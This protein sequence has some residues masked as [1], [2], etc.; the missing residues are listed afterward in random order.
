MYNDLN[1]I[2]FLHC[3]QVKNIHFMYL[4]NNYSVFKINY[5]NKTRDKIIGLCAIKK[6]FTIPIHV[7]GNHRYALKYQLL[8]SRNEHGIVVKTSLWRPVDRGVQNIIILK[9][10]Q[11]NISY[12]LCSSISV[13]KPFL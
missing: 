5:W 13:K 8:K 4:E 12:Y 10:I 9:Y 11:V 6:N 1:Q 3:L 7:N 2:F